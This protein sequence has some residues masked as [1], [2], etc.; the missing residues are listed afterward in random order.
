M[1]LECSEVHAT[2]NEPFD[3]LTVDPG[4]L[5]HYRLP[6]Q[7]LT[8]PDGRQLLRRRE[9]TTRRGVN[10]TGGGQTRELEVRPRRGEMTR[11]E[12]HT[13]VMMSGSRRK[14]ERRK[15]ASSQRNE[16]RKRLIQ[17][18]CLFSI[19]FHTSVPINFS[20]NS[21]RGCLRS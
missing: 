11:R 16:D 2:S 18:D 1:R 19:H 13:S 3:E 21:Q 15:A 4:T 14:S 17:T 5:P 12:G 9:L 8:P 20:C 7:L 6:H 10:V